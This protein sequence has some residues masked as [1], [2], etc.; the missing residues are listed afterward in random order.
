MAVILISGGTGLVGKALSRNLVNQGHEVRILSRNPKSSN[1]IKAFFWNVELKQIDE[2]AFEDVEHIVHLA[3]EGIADKRWTGK[4]KKE[5]IDSRVE[6]IKLITSV[7]K[8]K[9]IKLKS[10]VGASAIGYYGMETSDKVFS[11]EDKF[12]NDFLAVTCKYWEESY[13]SISEYSN[14]TSV[15][16]ISMVLSKNGGALERLKPIFKLGLGSALGSGKQ[17]MPWIHIE[18]LITIFCEALFNPNYHGVYN[19]ATADQTDNN[20][21]CKC[22][23]IV[24]QKPFFML[25]VPSFVL[26]IMFGEMSN[27]LLT[28]TRIDNQR[29]LKNGFLF[30]Y[31]DLPSALK[32]CI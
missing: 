4:R 11:E 8:E 10:F 9:N 14:K 15:L 5:I 2:K 32:N 29:L 6:S 27:M 31:P 30:K 24:L 22:L 28:G 3:G 20:T 26:K 1:G 19:V 7:V 16:R 21:F 12:G 13:T 17:Y 25:K 23:A 18:D